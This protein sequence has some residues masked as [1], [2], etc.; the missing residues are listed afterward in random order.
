MTDP[1]GGDRRSFLKGTAAVAVGATLAAGAAR[2]QD[3]EHQGDTRMAQLTGRVALVTGAA[4]GIGRAIAEGFAQ[5]GA[6]VVLLDIADPDAFRPQEGFRAATMAEFD[7]AVEAVGALG[8]RVLKIQADVR[9]LA[10]LEAAMEQTVNE[11]GGLDIVVTNAGF[12][13]WHSFQEGTPEDWQ[14]VYG[15]NVYGVFNTIKAA[16]P[17]LTQRGGG[18][19]ITISSIGGRQGV[20]GNGAYTSTKWAV[21]GLTKQAAIE[22]GPLNIAVNAIAPGPVNTP[23]Y[24]SEAQIASIGLNTPEEQDQALNAVLPLGDRPALEPSEIADA[25]VFLASDA[26][27]SISG[28]S[29]DVALGYNA[30]YTA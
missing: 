15:V 28:I 2:A 5:A 21:I 25:A 4:R 13:R 16:V 30:T 1:E 17:H 14:E 6:E 29:L 3:A 22:L 18:R 12:V 8:G 7:E 26:A 27:R 24:R 11:L 10:A 19:I 9:D 20:A 23:M